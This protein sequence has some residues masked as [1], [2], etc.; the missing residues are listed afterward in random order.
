MILGSDQFEGICCSSVLLC[1]GEA[2]VPPVLALCRVMLKFE[3]P[4]QL[5]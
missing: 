4:S 5:F 2:V 3:C 1:N